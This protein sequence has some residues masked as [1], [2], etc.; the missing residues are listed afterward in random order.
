[1]TTPI[2]TRL[3]TV[4]KEAYMNPVHGS[5]VIPVE[6]RPEDE[7]SEEEDEVVFPPSQ[8]V[9]HTQGQGGREE[10]EREGGRE[11]RKR[12]EEGRRDSPKVTLGPER[13]SSFRG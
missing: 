13:L 6:N 5:K 10:G 9:S 3:K 12:G 11:V 8:L 1:M 4:F 2:D 7:L